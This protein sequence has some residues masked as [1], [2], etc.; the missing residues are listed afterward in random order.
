MNPRTAVVIPACDEQL[1]VGRCIVSVALA[2]R[3]LLIAD[4]AA[5]VLVVLAADSCTDATVAVARKAWA[6]SSAQMRGRARLEVIDGRW[7]SAGATRRAAANRAL[8]WGPRWIASTDAD[9]VVP[10]NWLAHQLERERAG[11][12]AV[13]GTVEPDPA[14]CS[15]EVWSLWHRDHHLVEGHSHIHAANMGVRATAYVGA[16]GFPAVSVSEDEAL[17]EALRARGARVEA[18]DRVRAVTSGRLHGRAALGFAHHLRDLTRERGYS[19][20]FADR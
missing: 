5:Q 16:G 13:L 19:G 2:T 11:V 4:P 1:R 8:G 17:V 10:R 7:A 12:D 20:G 3:T 15:E 9:T 14:E 6:A 18:T